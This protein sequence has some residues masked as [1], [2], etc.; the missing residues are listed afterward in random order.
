MIIFEPVQTAVWPLRLDGTSA[1]VEV[2][3]QESVAGRYRPPVFVS[4]GVAPAMPPQIIIS[5]P[6]QI[7][8]WE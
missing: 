6:V 4:L 1:P 7:P 3:S 5:D 2:G 8:R